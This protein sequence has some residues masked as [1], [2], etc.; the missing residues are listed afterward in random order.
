MTLTQ[1]NN[2]TKEKLILELLKEKDIRIKLLEDQIL[3]L[4]AQIANTSLQ[5]TYPNCPYCL[6]HNNNIVYP[7]IS[8]S[9][10]GT[11]A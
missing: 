2:M 1:G 6:I 10:E 11:T 5:L 7:I 4:Q 8:Y 3:S 9:L